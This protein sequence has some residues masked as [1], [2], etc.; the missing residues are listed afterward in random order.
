MIAS[1][2]STEADL[3]SSFN[4]PASANYGTEPQHPRI[5]L[6][7][8]QKSVGV[9]S[10]FFGAKFNPT[11]QF[12]VIQVSANQSIGLSAK[13]D[14]I[15]FRFQAALDG[16][17]RLTQLPDDWDDAGGT[18]YAKEHVAKVTS[19]LS[20]IAKSVRSEKGVHLPV[21]RLNPGPGDSIDVH[22]KEPGKILL[23]N[24][25]ADNEK[26]STFYGETSGEEKSEI[27]GFLDLR[28]LNSWIA[29]WLLPSMPC[30]K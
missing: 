12:Q 14:F 4:P 17:D 9:H 20:T 6:D 23:L 15:D 16:A 8:A 18:A 30:T 19:F 22:W 25:P 27:R 26:L 11:T 3:L 13:G 5:R 2:P 1:K 29:E 21:P 10:P 24:I 28:Y 7:I